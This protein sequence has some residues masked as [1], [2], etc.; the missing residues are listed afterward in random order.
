MHIFRCGHHFHKSCLT[1]WLTL[2]KKCPLCKQDFRGK[3][4]E[5]DSQDEE[6]E[7]DGEINS[8]EENNTSSAIPM[9]QL[10]ANDNRL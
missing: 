5:E 3:E 6:D 4:Y 1:E 10:N 9:N 8:L 2:N 7:E